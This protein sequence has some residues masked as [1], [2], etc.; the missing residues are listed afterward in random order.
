MSLEHG[1][2][3]YLL[4]TEHFGEVVGKVAENLQWGP[5][6]LSYIISSS[7]ISSAKVSEG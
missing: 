3:C 5:K 1:K 4:L 6:P 2:L 7:K